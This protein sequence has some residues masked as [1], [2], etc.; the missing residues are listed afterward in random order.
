V[1]E[2]QV[3]SQNADRRRKVAEPRPTAEA[4]GWKRFGSSHLGYG[5]R[6]PDGWIVKKAGPYAVIF[7]GPQGTDAFFATVNIQTVE[8]DSG[9]TNESVAARVVRDLED[10][11][12]RGGE[13]VVVYSEGAFGRGIGRNSL[14]GQQFVAA[15]SHQNER[16]RQWNVVLP[17]TAEGVTHVW[18]YTA[19]ESSYDR[20]RGVAEKM[21]ASW[22]LQNGR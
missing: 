20:Y 13:D 5:I 8:S 17:R 4:A 14:A 2:A 7:S 10:Q 9:A 12:R 22:D 3:S 16:F 15:F 11:L 6:Y 18:S 21:L 19:P 1:P